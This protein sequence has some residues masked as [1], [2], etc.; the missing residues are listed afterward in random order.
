MNIEGWYKDRGPAPPA[1]FVR[2]VVKLP[3]L[4]IGGNVD[5]LVDPGADSSSLHPY[6]IRSLKIDHAELRPSSVTGR[7]I[8]GEL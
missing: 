4:D 6:D 1:P 3:R 5:F 2:A 7:G 8:G